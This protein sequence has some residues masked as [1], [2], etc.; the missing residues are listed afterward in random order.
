[1]IKDGRV[2]AAGKLD[3]LLATSAEMRSLWY[4]EVQE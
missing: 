3:E 1:V 2:E 4:G